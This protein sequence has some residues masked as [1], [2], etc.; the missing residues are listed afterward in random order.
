MAAFFWIHAGA[1]NNWGTVNN[2]SATSGGGTNGATPTT[3]SDVTFDGAGANGNDASTVSA[4]ITI[5]TLTFTTGYTNTVTINTAVQLTVSGNFTD[6]TQHSWVVSGTGNLNINATATITSNGKTFPGPVTLATSST[7]KTLSGDW[8]IT[9]TLTLSGSNTVNSGN[10]NIGGGLAGSGSSAGTTVY[11]LN[12]TGT[13]ASTIA[14]L[15]NSVTINTAG[16]ITMANGG[17]C[18]WSSGTLTYTAGTVVTTNN[19]LNVAATSTFNTNGITWGTITM[20]GTSTMTLN[21]LLS[22]SALTLS[23]SPIITFAGTSGFSVGTLTITGTTA[24]TT[25]LV[26]G[27]T[28]T[29]TSSFQMW[30]GLINSTLSGRCLITSDHATIKAILTLQAGAV[31]SVVANFTRIDASA[32]RT[33]NTFHGTVTDSTNIFSYTDYGGGI[34]SSYVWA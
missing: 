24:K 29:I 5:L 23:G 19:T 25:T 8:T 6:R 20:S 22:A 30:D 26:N 17:T 12:G 4:G 2:W 11:V 14:N 13:W 1:N 16:T 28:Y 7:T 32:G 31:C 33:I 34:A 21:S 10:L 9:G 27:V 3:T 15:T 18:N